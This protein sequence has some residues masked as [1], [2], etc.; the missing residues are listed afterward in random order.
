MKYSLDGDWEFGS[1][2]T[3][4]ADVDGGIGEDAPTVAGDSSAGVVQEIVIVR[5]HR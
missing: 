3:T 4:N 5:V 1:A 2:D